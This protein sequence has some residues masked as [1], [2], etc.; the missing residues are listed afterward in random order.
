MRLPFHTS[1]C[2]SDSFLASRN[3]RT[4]LDLPTKQL[5]ADQTSIFAAMPTLNAREGKETVRGTLKNDRR[6]RHHCTLRLGHKGKGVDPA[7]GVKYV[8]T[9][10][11]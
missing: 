8:E 11:N 10:G 6:I 1:L 5:L 9:I 4:Q 2:L 3:T 7:G